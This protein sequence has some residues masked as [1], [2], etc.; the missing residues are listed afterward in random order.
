MSSRRSV[1]RD[2]VQRNDATIQCARVF[3]GHGD[4]VHDDMHL[5]AGLPDAGLHVEVI[6]TVAFRAKAVPR[7]LIGVHASV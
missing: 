7:R 2:L 3:K 6:D 4:T 5:T 1:F